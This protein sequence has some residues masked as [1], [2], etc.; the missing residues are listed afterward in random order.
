MDDDNTNT[1]KRKGNTKY[2]NSYS[3]M[4]ILDAGKRLGFWIDELKGTPVAKMLANEKDNFDEEVLRTKEKVYY[5][6]VEYLDI[7]GYPTE[8]NHS[9]KE[10]NISDL[11]LS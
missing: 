8:V 11:V 3:N 5:N 6:I 9:F 1:K 7:E 4:T 10:A 2:N